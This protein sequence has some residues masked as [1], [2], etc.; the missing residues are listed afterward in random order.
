MEQAGSFWKLQVSGQVRVGQKPGV[1]ALAG[2][3]HSAWK[4]VPLSRFWEA[5]RSCCSLLQYEVFH[6]SLKA[7]EL[8]EWRS[9]QTV[10]PYL[11]FPPWPLN[12]CHR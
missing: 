4:D 2:Q 9:L 8:P 1:T 11:A 12:S 6:L 7:P 5:E 10:A 3:S